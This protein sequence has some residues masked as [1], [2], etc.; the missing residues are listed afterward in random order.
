ML[1][2]VSQLRGRILAATLYPARPRPKKNVASTDKIAGR[3]ARIDAAPLEAHKE[4][5][6]PRGKSYPICGRHGKNFPRIRCTSNC[7]ILVQLIGGKFARSV[8]ANGGEL[9]SSCT[10]ESALPLP[11]G[12]GQSL[13]KASI[14][15]AAYKPVGRME[16]ARCTASERNRAEAGVVAAEGRSRDAA[17]SMG[18]ANRRRHRRSPILANASSGRMGRHIRHSQGR[19][20]RHHSQGRH[21]RHHSPHSLGP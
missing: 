4:P 16:G 7:S 14:T 11:R 21:T 5:N 10:S 17:R 2:D 13:Q 12:R 15:L 8:S 1:K 18:K 3:A 20:T 9:A 6:T 19:H